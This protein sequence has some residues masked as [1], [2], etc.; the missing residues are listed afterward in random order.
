MK[1]KSEPNHEL[2]ALKAK[3]Q[4]I[5]LATSPFLSPVVTEKISHHRQH[6]LSSLDMVQVKDYLDRA[7]DAECLCALSE[8]YHSAP[9]KDE[10]YLI[11]VHLGVKVLTDAGQEL[12]DNFREVDVQA[13]TGAQVAEL[14]IFRRG[15]R[16][17]QQRNLSKGLFQ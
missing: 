4:A 10:Y 11:F 17:A 14:E 1:E 2:E 12:T 7:T 8:I 15:I 3:V 6:I 16:T 13:L 5:R 9:I